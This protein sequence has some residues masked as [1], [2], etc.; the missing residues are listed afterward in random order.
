MPAELAAG[1]DGGEE[2]VSLLAALMDHWAHPGA[3]DTGLAPRH[4]ASEMGKRREVARDD[5]PVRSPL[6]ALRRARALLM[7][8]RPR[9]A[10]VHA[11][12]QGAR[13][14]SVAERH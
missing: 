6:T 7:K 5:R 11:S 14:R 9:P 13:T 3:V 10:S 2:L 8:H 12:L 4:A 1:N